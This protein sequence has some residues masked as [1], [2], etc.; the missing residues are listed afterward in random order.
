MQRFELWRRQNRPTGFRIRTLQPLGYI[1]RFNY[2]TFLR[3]SPRKW[4]PIGHRAHDEF[5]E[6]FR[7][8]L[9]IWKNLTQPAKPHGYWIFGFLNSSHSL[10]FRVALVMT[11]S[12]LLQISFTMYYNISQKTKKSKI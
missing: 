6:N 11:S 8:E 1:S 4:V 5:G 2:L 10:I 12:I 3:I 7:R 9:A